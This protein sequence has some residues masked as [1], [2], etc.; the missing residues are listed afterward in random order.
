VIAL[1]LT[2]VVVALV[3]LGAL[4]L[5]QRE[6]LATMERQLDLER[7]EREQLTQLVDR[8]LDGVAEIGAGPDQPTRGVFVHDARNQRLKH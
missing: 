6:R 1:V 5:Q 3:V 4:A 7:R 2:L 8:L